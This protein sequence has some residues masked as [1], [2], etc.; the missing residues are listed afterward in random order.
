MS[1]LVSVTSRNA[2]TMNASKVLKGVSSKQS[3]S[4]LY[5]NLNQKSSQARFFHSA[6]PVRFCSSSKNMNNPE[7]I[8]E[9]EFVDA[10]AAEKETTKEPEKVHMSENE[11]LKGETDNLTFQAETQKLLQI[12]AHSLYSD[13]QVFVREII[14]NAS[15]ALEKLRYLQTTNET[16]VESNTELKIDLFVDEDKKIFAIQ[17]NGVGM[18][19]EE[20]CTNLGT[21]AHSGSKSFLNKLEEA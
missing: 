11:T 10:E 19:R 4:R 3:A 9:A 1:R 15:D 20:L 17:D 12:V 5:N 2:V 13:R 6:N 8:N 21:I 14:S 7:I 18:T 16:N